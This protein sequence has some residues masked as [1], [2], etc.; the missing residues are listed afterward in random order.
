MFENISRTTCAALASEYIPRLENKINWGLL[1][2]QLGVTREK[3][4]DLARNS[5]LQERSRALQICRNNLER[6]KM[7]VGSIATYEALHDATANYCDDRRPY[8][9]ANRTL[10][11][12]MFVEVYNIHLN[13]LSILDKDVR[14]YKSGLFST[15]PISTS[16]QNERVFFLNEVCKIQFELLYFIAYNELPRLMENFIDSLQ[17]LVDFVDMS[18]QSNIQYVQHKKGVFYASLARLAQQN[19]DWGSAINYGLNSVDELGTLLPKVSENDLEFSVFILDYIDAVWMLSKAFQM[20][21]EMPEA[22]EWA[23]VALKNAKQFYSSYNGE[24]RLMIMQLTKLYVAVA[25]L[26]SENY[27]DQNNHDAAINT[28]VDM[29]ETL[30]KF[31]PTEGRWSWIHPDVAFGKE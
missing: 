27:Y 4:V 18:I 17:D 20:V 14:T 7:G 5:I 19:D 3:L 28:L 6:S 21:G 15:T 11:K 16:D 22:L 1:P 12:L 29:N 9:G 26:Q 8:L 13:A 25:R 24:E 31:M 2:H 30:S 10:C 23:S